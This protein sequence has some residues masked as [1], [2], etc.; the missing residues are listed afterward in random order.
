MEGC[1]KCGERLTPMNAS[2][3]SRGSNYCAKCHF[4]KNYPIRSRL[5]KLT[6]QWPKHWD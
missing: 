5:A 2:A 6:G 4:I 1:K 3:N